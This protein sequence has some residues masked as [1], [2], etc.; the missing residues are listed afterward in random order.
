M[1]VGCSVWKLVGGMVGI[2]RGNV[3]LFVVIVFSVTA[4]MSCMC[5]CG[6]C[7]DGGGGGGMRRYELLVNRML[8]ICEVT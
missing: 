1:R 7:S 8:T 4:V 6:A 3:L 2:V 5:W